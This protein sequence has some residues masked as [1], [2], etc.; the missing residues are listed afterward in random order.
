MKLI[1]PFILTAICLSFTLMT[2][3][4]LFDQ[5]PDKKPMEPGSGGGGDIQSSSNFGSGDLLSEMDANATETLPGRPSH[6]WSP[7]PGKT[8]PTVYFAFDQS[9]IGTSQISKLEATADYLKQHSN[10]GVIIEGNCDE[11]GSAEYNIGLGEKRALAV[12]DYLNKLG[13]PDTRMQTI[14]YG[15]EKPADPG[16]N[17]NAWLKNRRANLIPANM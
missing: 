3:C 5:N 16:H 12:R 13:V 14:S 8:F 7:I 9:S 4:S 1:R 15:S 11:R 10:I 17:E 6:Q 2:A